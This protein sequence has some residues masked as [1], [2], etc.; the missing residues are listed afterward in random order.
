MFQVPQQIGTNRRTLQG[1]LTKA[2]LKNV[3]VSLIWNTLTG[4]E[5]LTQ[6]SDDSDD[7]LG[8]T[9][10]STES[11]TELEIEA[12]LEF[13]SKL[14]SSTSS[15]SGDLPPQVVPAAVVQPLNQDVS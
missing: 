2:S 14:S 3:N 9:K 5:S 8:T 11:S 6:K 15:S 1:N 4:G 10:S 7:L 12:E 13:L